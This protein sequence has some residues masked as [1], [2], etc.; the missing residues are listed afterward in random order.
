MRALETALFLSVLGLSCFAF[1]A[2]AVRRVADWLAGRRLRQ[3][4]GMF[5]VVLTPE[6]M[7]CARRDALKDMLAEAEDECRGS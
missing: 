2:V 7:A 3:E 4:L 1:L 6:E 5:V